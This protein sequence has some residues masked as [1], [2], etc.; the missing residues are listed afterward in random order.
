VAEL[1]AKDP[2]ARP[3]S[4]EL[5]G[6]R[7]LQ[8]AGLPVAVEPAQV[9]DSF[10]LAARFVGRRAELGRLTVAVDAACDGRGASWLVGGESGVGKSRLLDELRTQA[11]V[12][13]MQV[14]RGQAQRFRRLL[15]A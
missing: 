5:V 11:M 1:L 13:G 12:E 2:A 10:L 15:P 4:A 8:I 9:R 7:L 6:Q 3:A 14:L